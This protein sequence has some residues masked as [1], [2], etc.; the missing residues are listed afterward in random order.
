VPWHNKPYIQTNLLRGGRPH[1]ITALSKANRIK[2]KQ[3]GQLI[4]T[5][6]GF[7]GITVTQLTKKGAEVREQECVKLANKSDLLQLRS[8][9][10]PL[11]PREREPS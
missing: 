1:V 3:K 10:E 7:F 2:R 11:L 4:Q 8:E 9:V 6:T 5:P